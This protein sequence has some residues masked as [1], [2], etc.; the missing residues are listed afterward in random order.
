MPEAPPQ[1][2]GVRTAGARESDASDALSLTAEVERLESLKSALFDALAQP[3]SCAMPLVDLATT[4][5]NLLK[6]QLTLLPQ[7]KAPTARA[8]AAPRAQSHPHKR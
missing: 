8:E 7:T 4:Y 6:L 3:P 5:S 2:D 1:P